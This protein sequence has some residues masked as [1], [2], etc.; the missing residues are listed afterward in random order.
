M[1]ERCRGNTYPPR[2]VTESETGV[3]VL[4][5]ACL[6]YFQ[7]SLQGEQPLRSTTSE[8]EPGRFSSLFI[9]GTLMSL[10]APLCGRLHNAS[11]SGWMQLINSIP[12]GSLFILPLN[13]QDHI[14]GDRIRAAI[15][16]HP[17]VNN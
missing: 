14:L 5:G 10:A 13:L 11:R 8:N 7:R 12:L 1:G 4:P 9:V 6:R 17:Q 3:S 16:K 2:V 15:L